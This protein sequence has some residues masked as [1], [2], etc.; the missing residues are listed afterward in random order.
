[1]P[2]RLL[3]APVRQVLRHDRLS[4]SRPADFVLETPSILTGT[5]AEA[6]PYCLD[7]LRARSVYVAGPTAQALMDAPFYYLEARRRAA[8]VISVPWEHSPLACDPR[9]VIF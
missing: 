7:W 2:R 4:R 3:V 1:M 8:T 9:P 6:F 5:P